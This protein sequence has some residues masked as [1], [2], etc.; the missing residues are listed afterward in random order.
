[1]EYSIWA[2]TQTGLPVQIDIKMAIFGNMKVTL[3][4]FVFNPE[5]DES[6][7]LTELPEGY[8]EIQ[9]PAMPTAKPSEN[10]LIEMLRMCAEASQG[11]FP[12]SLNHTE[13]VETPRWNNRR[14]QSNG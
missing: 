9:M 11:K 5:V 1:M 8:K 13:R 4:D 6:L 2:D 12:D 10:D 7:F 14:R 3:S